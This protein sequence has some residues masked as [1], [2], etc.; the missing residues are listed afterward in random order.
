MQPFSIVSPNI[1]ISPFRF[2]RVRRPR[3]A[4]FQTKLHVLS[5]DSLDGG[6]L[7]VYHQEVEAS[8]E[9]V[10]I[11][12]N[13]DFDRYFMEVTF[14]KGKVKDVLTLMQ[15]ANRQFDELMKLSS[16]VLELKNLKQDNKIIGTPPSLQ[17][18]AMKPK[19]KINKRMTWAKS[20]DS[21]DRD[22]VF[23][24]TTKESASKQRQPTKLA[25]Q[26]L[27]IGQIGTPFVDPK[28]MRVLT[29]EEEKILSYRI[30]YTLKVD[31]L[32]EKVKKIHNRKAS[33]DELGT[34]LNEDPKAVEIQYREGTEARQTMIARNMRLVISI[35]AKLK[36]EHAEMRDLIVEGV[37][38]LMRAIEKFDPQK[39]FK[40]ST[41]AH[42]WIRQTISRSLQNSTLVVKL[43]CNVIEE[44]RRMRVARA[45][46][47]KQHGVVPDDDTLAEILGLKKKR[48]LAIKN[49]YRTTV[50]I[51]SP[52]RQR[53][54]ANDESNT[55]VDKIKDNRS[56]T[57]EEYFS[58]HCLKEDL[59]VVLSTLPERES[60]VLRLRYG[61]DDGFQRTLEKV[62]LRFN[63]C[64]ERIRQIEAKALRKLQ[65]RGRNLNDYV[66]SQVLP[67]LDIPVSAAHLKAS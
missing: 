66:E 62:G 4:N 2:G 16:G 27:F 30:Q 7:Q 10:V 31:E 64:R 41:Y 33:W 5:L 8:S 59:E 22:D 60:K 32:K 35:A 67:K 48:Y 25:P 42:W 1:R 28:A 34:L 14:A 43:P 17:S 44:H 54:G 29:R 24:K 13:S 15:T 65:Q 37:F 39:G 49:A 3:A 19:L 20:S 52:S 46:Y 56:P 55:L 63:V 53:S 9:N 6:N 11:L 26:E 47:L 38:G 45:D 23:I 57:A 36:T 18:I 50:S 40:L 12:N 61:L 21:T 51:E 58:R